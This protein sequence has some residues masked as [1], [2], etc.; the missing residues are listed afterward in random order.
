MITCEEA[1]V[2][3]IEIELPHAGDV[4]LTADEWRGLSP[5]ERTAA[6]GLAESARLARSGL[7]AGLLHAAEQLAQAYGEVWHNNHRSLDRL[8]VTQMHQELREAAPGLPD[9]LLPATTGQ[10]AA[11]VTLAAEAAASLREQLTES[12]QQAGNLWED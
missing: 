1:P 8:T 2:T 10:L 9:H 6:A 3:Y 12:W 7:L 11:T 5:G 4:I